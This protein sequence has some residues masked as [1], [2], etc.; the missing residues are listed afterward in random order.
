MELLAKAFVEKTSL[1]VRERIN[2]RVEKL[3]ACRITVSAE[4]ML[5]IPCTSDLSWMGGTRS[6]IKVH[7]NLLLPRRIASARQVDGH[8]IS[9][10]S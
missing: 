8:V 5:G 10:R 7:L 4:L 2:R 3:T 9:Y 6:A 1:F